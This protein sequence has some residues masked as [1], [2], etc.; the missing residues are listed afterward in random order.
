MATLRSAAAAAICRPAISSHSLGRAWLHDLSTKLA[1]AA[2]AGFTGI[3][4]FHEDVVYHARDL[5]AHSDISQVTDKEKIE[6]CRE[7]ALLCNKLRLRVV[8]LQPFR[9]FEGLIDPRAL[10]DR[11]HDFQV[12]IDMAHVLHTDMIAIA[13]TLLPIEE[14]VGDPVRLA[15]DLAAFADAGA[16]AR[17]PIRFTYEALCFGTHTRSWEQAADIVKRAD[18]PNMGLCLDT[19]NIAGWAYADPAVAGGMRPDGP[20]RLQASLSELVRTID[21]AKIFYI[22]VV[23]AERMTAP[24][25]D[26]HP[27][28]KPDQPPR[29]SWSRGCRL[30]YG[31]TEHGAYLPI[32]EI[33]T[34]I[35]EGLGWRGWVSME[36][37]NRSL[38]EKRDNVPE[39]HAARAMASWERLVLD[40]PQLKG[41]FAS[42]L[43]VDGAE[44]KSVTTEDQHQPDIAQPAPS[45]ESRL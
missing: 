29:M 40:F 4:L 44:E 39:E 31:E 36:L 22:Q 26:G 5:F 35:V 18:R 15:T 19:F 33:M 7:I 41:A 34:A 42:Q 6:A 10:G 2:A 3:E 38:E 32:K 43:G 1:Y 30:F 21:P 23:D 17:P 37:F 13:S 12:W 27:L 16:A 14:T 8:C 28:H 11:V 45:V 20:E 9:N 24:L 25:I